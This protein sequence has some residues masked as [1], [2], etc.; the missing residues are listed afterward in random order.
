MLNVA[1]VEGTWSGSFLSLIHVFDETTGASEWSQSPRQVAII[2][3]I[4]LGGIRAVCKQ[5]YGVNWYS[6]L[7][8]FLTG[9]LSFICVWLNEF[10]A[11]SLTGTTEPL[12]SILCKGP[13]TTVHAIVPAITMGFGVFDIIEGFSHGTDFVRKFSSQLCLL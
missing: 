10:A 7:H 6:L 1:A 13:L 12:G 3:A 4:L 5:K 2:S 9:L 11:V 8:A